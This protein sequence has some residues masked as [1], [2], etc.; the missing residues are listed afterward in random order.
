[1]ELEEAVATYLVN[2]PGIA[3]IVVDRV[4]PVGE[5]IVVPCITYQRI[6]GQR[7]L[8]QS[9]PS[10]WANP[11]LSMTCWSETY[12]GAKALAKQLRIALDGYK[13][14]MGTV[15]IGKAS[16]ENDVDDRDD[17][18][19]WYRIIVDVMFWNVEEVA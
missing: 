3:G 19:G 10:G 6:S 12:S 13:G 11:R 16:V 5:A 8:T 14:L 15:I 1:M 7:S 4:Q 17:D 9:G 2:R 18:S